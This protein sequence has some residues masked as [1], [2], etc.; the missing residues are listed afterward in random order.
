MSQ[1]L[2]LTPTG[3]I[4]PSSLSPSL[5]SPPLPSSSL[6]PLFPSQLGLHAGPELLLPAAAV[7]HGPRAPASQRR[8]HTGPRAPLPGGSGLSAVATVRGARPPPV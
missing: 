4:S 8:R 1:T 5:S 2:T 3:L 6:P 7:A